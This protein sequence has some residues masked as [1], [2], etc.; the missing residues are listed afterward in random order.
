MRSLT[1]ITGL[2]STAAAVFP[3]STTKPAAPTQPEPAPSTLPPNTLP[4]SSVP[5]QTAGEQ[6]KPSR[7]DSKIPVGVVTPVTGEL[8]C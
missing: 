8:I 3:E 6:T 7:Q 5:E 1:P 2:S 4:P